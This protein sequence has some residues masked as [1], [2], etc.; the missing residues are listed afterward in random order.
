MAVR[1]PGRELI[2]ACCA[3]LCVGILAALVQAAAREVAA[4]SP[5]REKPERFV[6]ATGMDCVFHRDASSAVT[7]I[8][9]FIAGGKSA[10]PEAKDGLAYLAS[11]LALEI[12]DES[13]VRDIMGQATRMKVSVL[14]DCSVIS[15]ECLSE[16][17]EDML[18][19]ASGIIQDPLLSG[20]RIDRSKKIA[21]LEGQALMD[22]AVESGH[23][24]ALGA[25]FAGRGRGGALYGTGETLQAV[26]K[27][28]ITTF[29]KSR[30]TRSG[31]FF[32][33]CT[34]I[35]ADRIR[36]LLE[37]YFA[38]FPAGEPGLPPSAPPS[39][40]ADKRI[41]LVRDTQQ[42]YVGRAYLLPSAGGADFAR[43][44]LLEVLLGSGPGSRLWDLRSTGGLAYSVG[45][46]STWTRSG[47]IL[48]AYLETDNAKRD[49]AVGAL[50]AVLEVLHDK[51]VSE[52][53]LAMTKAMAKSGFLRANEAK[54]ARARTMGLFETLGLGVEYLS[55]IFRAIEAVSV[56][57]LNDFIDKVLDPAQAVGIAVGPAEISEIPCPRW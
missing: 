53:E 1:I 17:L 25:F 14:E 48:E 5:W 52:D 46:R 57:E 8:Q 44:F 23:A 38:G 54:A 7:I 15:L 3:S 16:N 28:D 47:G 19:V 50:N 22:D 36:K 13:I 10:V 32:S 31:I 35:D 40:P 2:K 56:G 49:R 11:R 33:V 41:V 6:L 24:A 18:R 27:K 37:K 9:L 51:G 21:A 29:Y 34:D 20:L 12:P 30:F 45:A 39:L 26:D 55:G 4:S 42:T 43:G